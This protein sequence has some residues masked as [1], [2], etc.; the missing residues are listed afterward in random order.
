MSKI[1]QPESESG[2]KTGTVVRLS[3]W[4]PA[5]TQTIRAETPLTR[6]QEVATIRSIIERVRQQQ[7]ERTKEEALRQKVTTFH[8]LVL[9]TIPMYGL[10]HFGFQIPA[11]ADV[12]TVDTV[13]HQMEKLDEERKV[14][15]VKGEYVYA[16]RE[17]PQKSIIRQDAR[18]QNYASMHRKFLAE[19]PIGNHQ[20]VRQHPILQ[21]LCPTILTNRG[22][23][24][25]LLKIHKDLVLN[26]E[27]FQVR[28]FDIRIRGTDPATYEQEIYNFFRYFD[29][30]IEKNVMNRIGILREPSDEEPAIARTEVNTDEIEAL[31]ERAR[32]MKA[33]FVLQGD[34]RRK[35]AILIRTSDIRKYIP[36]S[37]MGIDERTSE[38]TT[39][40]HQPS[41]MEYL[42][43]E[44]EI[45]V[46]SA[47][48][49]LY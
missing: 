27:G 48:Q 26:M 25:R 23:I 31:D 16:E 9:S 34:T 15:M 20:I 24:E 3:E 44:H 14:T 4:T 12:K 39:V 1:R 32:I 45:S 13:Y 46:M 10:D 2:G 42:R 30:S 28:G 21:N 47:G 18:L 11:M 33:I 43:Y 49:I 19:Q 7:E 22:L 29:R 40:T 35:A 37:V 8:T 41:L 5:R 36:L 6:S 38:G 17:V